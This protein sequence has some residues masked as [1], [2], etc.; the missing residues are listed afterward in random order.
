MS[1]K[2]SEKVHGLR[3]HFDADAAPSEAIE[4]IWDVEKFTRS[5]PDVLS[6]EILEQSE[7][8]Q[9]VRY[10]IDAELAILCP[11]PEPQTRRDQA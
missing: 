11:Q 1:E 2:R 3:V 7:A 5:F 9:R 8:H 6:L 10:V 4:L